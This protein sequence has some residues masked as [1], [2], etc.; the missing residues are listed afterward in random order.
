MKR[1]IDI[2]K[3]NDASKFRSTVGMLGNNHDYEYNFHRVCLEEV[4]ETERTHLN[5]HSIVVD[6][7]DDSFIIL[8]DILGIYGDCLVHKNVASRVTLV[9]RTC[10]LR[11]C[12]ANCWSF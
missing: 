11:H 5:F 4:K 10:L 6:E 2:I 8:C 9:L 1:F 12:G 7:G 3:T